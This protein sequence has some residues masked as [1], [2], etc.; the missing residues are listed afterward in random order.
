M[1]GTKVV[2]AE[3]LQRHVKTLRRDDAKVVISWRYAHWCNGL[4]RTTRRRNRA[5]GMRSRTIS[6][7]VIGKAI[8]VTSSN[9]AKSWMFV[10]NSCAD[11]RETYSFF[12]NEQSS[13]K[14]EQQSCESERECG[15]RVRHD[16]ESNVVHSGTK[17]NLGNSCEARNGDE[18]TTSS[19]VNLE[20]K[21]CWS[22]KRSESVTSESDSQFEMYVCL[23]PD[24]NDHFSDTRI[25]RTRVKE[26]CCT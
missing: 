6:E 25:S 24:C 7:R 15:G 10:T 8:N 12:R 4:R 11:L 13:Y 26:G 9:D 14:R 23:R 1:G 2:N 21:K 17:L 18:G 19:H 16:I 5:T 20:R 3:V 22:V